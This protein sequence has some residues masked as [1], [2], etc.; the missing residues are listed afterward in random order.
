MVLEDALNGY[1]SIEAAREHY[2]VAIDP[3]TR[4]IDPAATERLRRRAP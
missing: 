1:V 3:V 4:K 2:G